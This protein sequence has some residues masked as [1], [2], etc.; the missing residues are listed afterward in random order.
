LRAAS[1]SLMLPARSLFR[2]IGARP[3]PARDVP[4]AAGEN[5]M[6][7]PFRPHV[8]VINDTPAILQVFQQLLEDEGF[9]VTLDTFSSFDSAEK[10]EQVKA[11]CPDVI[12]LD[13]IIGGEPLGW[14]LLQLLRMDRDTERTPVVVCTA[15]VRQV[16]ELGAHLLTMNVQVVLKPFDID[17][18]LAAVARALAL[19]ARPDGTLADLQVDAPHNPVERP[20]AG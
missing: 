20:R 12:V 10:L 4:A 3:A 11:L 18:V 6:D 1:K 8:L 17:A 15:A 5:P 13:F 16:E 2:L 19:G 9:R 14:Q 7:E